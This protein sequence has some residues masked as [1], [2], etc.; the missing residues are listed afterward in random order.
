MP[1]TG[2]DETVRD[3]AE[4]LLNVA[5]DAIAEDLRDAAPYDTGEL[6]DSAYVIVDEDALTTTVGFSAPQAGFTNDGTV[7]HEIHARDAPHLYFFWENG[8]AGPGHYS[9]DSVDHPGI[10]ESYEHIHWFT[11]IVELW[12]DYIA[13]ALDTVQS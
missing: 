1:I 6:V 4:Q 8:P 3:Y 11:Q 2:L 5:S 7:S 12:P 13:D 9:F 10:D